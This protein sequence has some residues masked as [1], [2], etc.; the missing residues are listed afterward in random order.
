MLLT[1]L[2]T[3]ARAAPGAAGDL[4]KVRWSVPRAPGHKFK[5]RL[6]ISG[7]SQK[8]MTDLVRECRGSSAR[9]WALVVKEALGSSH[10]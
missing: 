3:R 5:G 8:E 4:L 6:L 1:V 10:A 9:L 2:L 7:L